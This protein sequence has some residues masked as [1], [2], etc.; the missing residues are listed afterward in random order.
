ACSSQTINITVSAVNDA[1][2]ALPFSTSTNEDQSVTGVINT[3]SDIDSPDLIYSLLSAGSGGNLSITSNGNFTFLPAINFNGIFTTQYRVCDNNS[4]CTT[5]SF[6]I[7]VVPVN[8]IPIINS[9]GVSTNEDTPVSGNVSNN[10]VDVDGNT[11][12]YTTNYNNLNGVFLLQGNGSFTFTPAL[13]Y[14]GTVSIP[15]TGCDPSNACAQATLTL[16]IMAVNDRPNANNINLTTNEDTPVS[17]SLTQN[18]SD[19]EILPLSFSVFNVSNGTVSV[20]GSG[21]AVFTPAMNYNGSAGYS[22]IACDVQG[23]CDTAQ[24]AISVVAINDAPVAGADVFNVNED[25][26]ISGNL[27]LNDSDPENSLLSFSLLN[28]PASGN[29]IINANGTFNY[30]PALNFNG[31]I[32]A[33]YQVCDA[34]NACSTGNITFVLAPV[35]DSPVA[36]NG[37]VTINEDQSVTLNLVSLVSDV[38]NNTFTFS[39]LSPSNGTLS[40]N[41]GVVQYQPSPNFFGTDAF[42]FIV[43]DGG[44]ACDTGNYNI[45]I[46][47]VNDGPSPVNDFFSAAEDNSFTGS[48]ALNDLNPDNTL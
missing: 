35:N 8:D 42:Q 2:I 10:D 30:S 15:Y 32:N 29:L 14:S 28:T 45:T 48:V 16:T 37:I 34:Q 41:S 40:I 44:G 26:S 5:A 46:I 4:L 3:A 6:S 9:E 13:N 31:S 20:S 18:S 43:C 22:Y 24:V 19:A 47:G 27:A 25:Q 17:V 21:N 12:S 11:L 1:P 36:S 23:L 33:N 7:T 38:D 39:V